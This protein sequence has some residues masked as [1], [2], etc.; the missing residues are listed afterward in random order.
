[1]VGLYTYIT[2]HKFCNAIVSTGLDSIELYKLYWNGV[3]TYNVSTTRM[4]YYTFKFEEFVVMCNY[5]REVYKIDGSLKYYDY[6][7]TKEKCVCGTN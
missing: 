5:I 7:D 6:M 1:M 4:V 2:M 3:V